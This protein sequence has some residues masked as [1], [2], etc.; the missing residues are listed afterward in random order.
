M[1]MKFNFDKYFWDIVVKDRKI[2]YAFWDIPSILVLVN[3]F[4]FKETLQNPA[5]RWVMLTVDRL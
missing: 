1:V 4:C 3:K 5:N 2:S